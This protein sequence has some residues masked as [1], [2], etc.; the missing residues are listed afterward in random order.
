MP[1]V[2]KGRLYVAGKKKVFH[3]QYYVQGQEFRKTLH[4]EN[5]NPVTNRRDAERLAAIL[6]QP[7]TVKEQASRMEQIKMAAEGALSKAARI[8]AKAEELKAMEEERRKERL[9]SIENAWTL[10]LFLM[11][12]IDISQ[13]GK[14]FL[15]HK[16]KI[17]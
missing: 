13:L 2:T 15:R 16:I 17:S 9:A 14:L 12:C 4:D 3:I 5:G 1:R 11:D 8:E 6:M 7:F 10:F